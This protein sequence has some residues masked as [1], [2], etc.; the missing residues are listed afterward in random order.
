MSAITVAPRIR[1][2]RPVAAKKN[3]RRIGDGVFRTIVEMAYEMDKAEKI[4]RFTNQINEA[5]QEAEWDDVLT[6]DDSEC[7]QTII[8]NDGI[9][10]HPYIFDFSI[11]IKHL[12]DYKQFIVDTHINGSHDSIDFIYDDE[13]IHNE[14]DFSSAM[15]DIKDTLIG[16]LLEVIERVSA[17]V[18]AL[19]ALTPIIH[20]QIDGLLTHVNKQAYCPQRPPIVINGNQMVG[21]IRYRKNHLSE[22]MFDSLL[23]DNPS[24]S[25][26]D[27]YYVQKTSYPNVSIY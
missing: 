4:T 3:L 13:V 23:E 12:I 20:R 14:G 18:D 21:S 11:R 2:K 22:W 8:Y 9:I 27:I 24:I 7:E 6:L 10:N 5:F 16:R 1:C 17:K 15:E 26:A 19:E 25:M